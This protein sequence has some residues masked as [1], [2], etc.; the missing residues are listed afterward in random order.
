[1]ESL[2]EQ[3]RYQNGNLSREFVAPILG[4]IALDPPIENEA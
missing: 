1:M 4:E 2:D 3:E